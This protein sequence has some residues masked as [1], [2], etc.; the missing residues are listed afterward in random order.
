MSISAKDA[1]EHTGGTPAVLHPLVIVN[2]TDHVTR[3]NLPALGKQPTAAQAARSTR[4]VGCLLGQQTGKSLEVHSSFELTYKTSGD[5][6]VVDGEFLLARQAGFKQVFPEY[7]IVGWYTSGTGLSANDIAVTHKAIAEVVEDPLVLVM[8]VNPAK[9]LKHL[10]LWIFESSTNQSTKE[11]TLRKIP[12]SVES[13]EIERIGIESAMRVDMTGNSNPTL[14][15]QADRIRSAMSMLQ[16]RIA[17]VVAYLKAVKKGDVPPDYELLRRISTVVNQ[18][19][20][21]NNPAFKATFTRDYEDA[22]LIAFLGVVTKGTTCLNKLI[23]DANATVDRKRGQ[24]LSGA[25]GAMM[26]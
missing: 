26:F 7:D 4:A 10:P 16:V 11:V 13:E 9:G 17:V 19:P 12:Y 21:G 22:L 24:A 5:H 15:P 6:V 20:R 8:D 25:L 2:I 1:P 18:L 3:I 23:V 14:A